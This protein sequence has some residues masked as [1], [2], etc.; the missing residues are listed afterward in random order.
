MTHLKSLAAP[1]HYPT[2]RTVFTT[3][4]RP[5]PHPKNWSIPLIIIIRDFLNYAEDAATARKIIKMRKVTV[6]GRVIT[7]HKFP[8]G[9]MD[10]ISLPEAGEHYRILP[11]PRKG[12]KPFKIRDEE[13]GFKIGQVRNKMHVRG[14]DLQLTLHDGRNIRFKNVD[15]QVRGYMTGDSLK[16][17]L[18]DQQIQAHIPLKEEVYVLITKGSKMGLHGRVTAIKKDVTYPDKPKV[19]VEVSGK[20]NITTLLTYVMPVGDSEPWIALP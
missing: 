20:G 6:D 16:I 3:A 11:E 7:D 2:T 19:V 8:V 15:E 17:S 10:V 4:P 9:L 18:P 14:G 1:K 5:G 13:A 12:L